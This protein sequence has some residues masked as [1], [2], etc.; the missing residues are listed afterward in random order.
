[1][2]IWKDINGVEKHYQVSSAGRVRKIY[3]TK[4]GEKIKMM[5]PHYY[6]NGYMFISLTVKKGVYKGF[7]LHR[8]VADTFIPNPENKSDVNHK[9]GNIHNNSV[10]NLEW[11]T[12]WENLQHAIKIG[13]MESQCKIRRKVTISKDGETKEF[14]SMKECADF[15]GFKKGWLQNRI[16]KY[17]YRFFY[18]GYEITISNER[19]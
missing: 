8:L 4:N 15:F 1:M 14:N 16:R 13:L 17:G 5:T 12:R 19:G 6:S 7:L 10:E 2:E 3:N 11:C 9:D 18:S